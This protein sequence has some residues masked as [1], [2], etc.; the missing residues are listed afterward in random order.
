MKQPWIY[1]AKVDGAFILAPAL[2]ITAVILCFRH[3]IAATN[4]LPLW[5]WG[6]LIIGVDVAHVYGTLFR[7]YTDAD[8]L[9]ARR[10]LY[11][12]APLLGWIAGTLLYSMGALMF[13]RAIAYLA[14]FHFMRQQYGFMMIYG[15]KERLPHAALRLIDKAAIYMATLYPL[16]Y[17]HTHMPRHFDWFIEG[18]FVAVS[19]PLLPAVALGVYVAAMALYVA[20]ECWL[21]F[22]NHTFNVPK[23]LL[24]AGTALSWWVGIISFNND[25]AFTAAN[26]LAHGIPYIALIWIYGRNQSAV[27]PGKKMLG[28][29]S[30]RRFFS[31][32]A[33]PLFIGILILFAYVEEGLWDGFIWT[34]HRGIFHPF[35]FLPPIDDKATLAW[36]VPLLALPQITHYV[37]DAFIWRLKEKGT[38]WKRVLFYRAEAIS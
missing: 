4:A 29:I 8:E 18:D 34:E 21:V 1:S 28:I 35:R 32:S 7:T 11:T 16:I 13:W 25:L 15:R 37:L 22:K 26:V 23:N 14:V 27:M 24:L 6:V 17:W 5:M 36:L 2:L 38:Q 33:L 30:W 31:V 12:L 9:R 3:S 20:K 10:A 19:S